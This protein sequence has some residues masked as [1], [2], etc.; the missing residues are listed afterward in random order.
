MRYFYDTEF[1]EN[2]GEA[3]VLISIGMVAEDGREY[4]AQNAECDLTTANAWVKANVIPQLQMPFQ[5]QSKSREIIATELL[6]FIG[7]DMPEFWGYCSAFDHLLLVQLFKGFDNMPKHWPYFTHDIAQLAHQL[8]N[9]PLPNTNPCVH[10]A[11]SDARWNMEAYFHLKN[12]QA[13]SAGSGDTD[14][15][16]IARV[17]NS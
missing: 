7:D 9:P 6:E 8:D 5:T 12:L 4:Y 16:L 2:R 3:V 15:S 10:H 14:E 17:S 1:I 13:A 11:L